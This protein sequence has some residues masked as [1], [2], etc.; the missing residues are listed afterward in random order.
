MAEKVC[1]MV[2]K[3]PIGSNDALEAFRLSLGLFVADVE[4]TV[5]LVGDGVLNA[6]RHL[7]GQE[8]KRP[9][10]Q[11]YLQAMADSGLSIWAVEEDLVARGLSEAMVEDFV[12][13]VGWER[14]A[15]MLEAE[16][17][18]WAF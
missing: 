3:A 15:P 2:R 6:V 16:P 13:V 10:P 18:I 5:V 1:M 12:Q 9:T 17:L 8:V 11:E 4:A 14:L 7:D